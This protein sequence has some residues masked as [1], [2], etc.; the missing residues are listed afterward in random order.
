MDQKDIMQSEISQRKMIIV[1]FHLYMK[2]KKQTKEKQTHKYRNK[3]V[4]SKGG[5]D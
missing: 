2:Y 3:L 1:G 4:I 5:G